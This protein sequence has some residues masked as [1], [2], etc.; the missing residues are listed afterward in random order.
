MRLRA[1]VLIKIS[2]FISFLILN[3]KMIMKNKIDD[4]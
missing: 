1:L 3:L 2:L 4:F